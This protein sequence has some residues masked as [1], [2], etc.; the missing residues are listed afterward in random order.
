MGVI[1]F[2]IFFSLLVA[3][4]FLAA[5]FWAVKSGQF[6]DPETPG[7]RMLFDN[8]HTTNNKTLTNRGK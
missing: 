3:L 6:D 7:M 4:L 1:I 8:D 5:F 2:L